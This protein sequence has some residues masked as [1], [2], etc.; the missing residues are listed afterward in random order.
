MIDTVTGVFESAAEE[1][2]FPTQHWTTYLKLAPAEKTAFLSFMRQVAEEEAFI[3]NRPNVSDEGFAVGHIPNHYMVVII[4]SLAEKTAQSSGAGVE[5][6]ALERILTAGVPVDIGD[7]RDG[8]TALHL[9]ALADA[10]DDN[11][12]C[13]TAKILL[14]KG[15]RIDCEGTQGFTTLSLAAGANGMEPLVSFLV[16]EGADINHQDQE[17]NPPLYHAIFADAWTPEA[18]A[19]VLCEGAPEF[20]ETVRPVPSRETVAFLVSH[21]K[22]NWASLKDVQEPIT[23]LKERIKDT[24]EDEKRQELEAVLS[25]VQDSLYAYRE[26]QRLALGTPGMAAL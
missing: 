14:G 12:R 19:D 13:Q 15:A 25:L 20:E 24:K 1:K 7:E 2:Q 4:Y 6:E 22:F 16:K 8:M 23:I 17:G 9:T 26:E 10:R 5:T 21:P 3:Q 11:T 18:V